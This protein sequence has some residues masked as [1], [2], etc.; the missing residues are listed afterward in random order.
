MA[1]SKGVT[2][3]IISE[4]D[5][6]GGEVVVGGEALVV[7]KYPLKHGSVVSPGVQVPSQVVLPSSPVWLFDRQWLH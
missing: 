6:G 5:E 7:E 4:P 3:E 1:A 2:R